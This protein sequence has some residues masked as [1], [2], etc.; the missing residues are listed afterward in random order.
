MENHI[1]QQYL[2]EEYFVC[3]RWRKKNT[4]VS[5]RRCHSCIWVEKLQTHRHGGSWSPAGRLQLCTIISY[6]EICCEQWPSHHVDLPIT[7]D[8]GNDLSLSISHPCFSIHFETH[9]DP[10]QRCPIA[11]FP[12][13]S[14]THLSLHA[15]HTQTSRNTHTFDC[16]CVIACG[17]APC[18]V[19]S[20]SPLIHHWAS[21]VLE[22]MQRIRWPYRLC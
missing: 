16:A 22:Q 4:F 9:S 15:G 3:F 8:L 20:S 10:L 14:D 17:T 5:Q 7:A 18:V 21:V 6:L 11:L 1:L 2:F 13:I 19:Q 12:R